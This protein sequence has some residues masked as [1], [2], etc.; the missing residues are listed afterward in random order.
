VS[1]VTLMKT[2]GEERDTVFRPMRQVLWIQRLFVVV[3][4]VNITLILAG[5][6]V[7]PATIGSLAGIGSMLGDVGMQIVLATLALAGPWSFRRYRPSIGI[8]VALGLVFAALY[9]RV[10]LLEFQG[11][12]TNANIVALFVGVAFI[13]GL[14]AGYRTG[15]WRQ[16][17][18]AAIWALVIGTALWSAAVLLINY[19][20]WGSHQQYV[21]W[22][23]DGAV[24]DFRRSGS[25]DFNAFLLQDLQGALFFHPV[26]SVVVGAMSGLIGS[27][28]AQGVVVLQQSFHRRALR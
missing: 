23:N 22:L 25:H 9:A 17:L 13:A 20:A 11:I 7:V 3:I 12:H 8:I 21:F 6:F 16:G 14:A 10:I 4:G 1:I 27:S 28:A 19:V 24:D 5:L 26:L 18:G 15:Q 2:P